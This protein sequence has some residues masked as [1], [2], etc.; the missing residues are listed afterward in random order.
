LVISLRAQ[1][2]PHSLPIH[3]AT[4]LRRIDVLTLM[5]EEAPQGYRHGSGSLREHY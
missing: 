1:A 2:R 3:H 4:R 5:P